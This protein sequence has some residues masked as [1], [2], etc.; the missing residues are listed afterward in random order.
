MKRAE[1]LIRAIHPYLQA[2]SG[3]SC[4]SGETKNRKYGKHATLRVES[5]HE[6][7]STLVPKDDEIARVRVTR[8]R[9]L[10]V[11]SGVETQ[12]FFL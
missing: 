5:L 3:T 8:A 7:R 1:R 12:S 10:I 4:A 6:A 2:E 9:D 11:F